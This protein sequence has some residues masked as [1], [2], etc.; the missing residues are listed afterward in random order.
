MHVAGS[1][2]LPQRFTLGS[3]YDEPRLLIYFFLGSDGFDGV[4]EIAGGSFGVVG[5]F[6]GN[7]SCG[8]LDYCLAVLVFERYQDF[9]SFDI[10]FFEDD[11]GYLE[12]SGYFVLAVFLF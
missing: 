4:D 3:S 12:G 7:F 8:F 2:R 1:L 5:R 10:V 6:L 11:G 9:N